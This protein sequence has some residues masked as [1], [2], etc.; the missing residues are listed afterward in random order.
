M[1][2]FKLTCKLA[3]TM[4]WDISIKLY[5]INYLILFTIMVKVAPQINYTLFTILYIHLYYLL[6]YIPDI[7]T[8]KCKLR[9]CSQYYIYIIRKS[10]SLM[11][12]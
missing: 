11:M 5:T 12:S 2:F 1:C 4:L 8:L 6:G 9:L 10:E 3:L 7:D